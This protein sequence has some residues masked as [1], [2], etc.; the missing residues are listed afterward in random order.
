MRIACECYTCIE[1]CFVNV[2]WHEEAA[3]VSDSCMKMRVEENTT[4]MYFKM[5][6]LSLCVQKERA[7]A[8]L[9]NQE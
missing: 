5:F 9:C 7:L 2:P 1:E 8:S 4:E 3:G 6:C